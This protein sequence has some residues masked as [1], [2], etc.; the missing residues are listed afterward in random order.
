[1]SQ[2]PGSPVSSAPNRRRTPEGV[3]STVG[4]YAVALIRILLWFVLLFATGAF[5]YVAVR[6]VIW[7]VRLACTALGV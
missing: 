2:N 4:N 6:G 3:A 5:V 7:A 1:M